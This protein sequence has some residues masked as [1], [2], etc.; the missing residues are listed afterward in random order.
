[1]NFVERNPIDAV[2]IALLSIEQ[3]NFDVTLAFETSTG[4]ITILRQASGT[5]ISGHDLRIRHIEIPEGD[6][7][8]LVMSKLV[9]SS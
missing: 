8:I 6:Q 9:M 5:P 3:N 7:L 1:M 4:E 2:S